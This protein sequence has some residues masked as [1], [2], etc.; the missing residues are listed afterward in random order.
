MFHENECV[1][2]TQEQLDKWIAEAS[3]LSPAHVDAI[4]EQN[5]RQLRI[6]FVG[7]T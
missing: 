5:K 1:I 6:M 2:L 4:R 7:P 3:K